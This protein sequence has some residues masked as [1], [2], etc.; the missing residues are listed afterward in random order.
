MQRTGGSVT[1]TPPTPHALIV[2]GGMEIAPDR[3]RELA[4]AASLI[5]AADSGLL[6]LRKGGM[7]PDAVIG[8]LDSL[9]PED[10]ARL[11][12]DQVHHDPGQEDTDLEKAIRFC[13]DRGI[14]SANIVGATGGRL[15]HTLNAISLLLKYSS[16]MTFTLHD[17][18]GSATLATRSPL[19]FD[20]QIG[21]RISLIPAPAAYGL[22]SRGLRYPLDGFDLLFGGRDAVSNAVVSAPVE[23]VW[24]N[25]SFLL[26]RQ[27]SQ[28]PAR[29]TG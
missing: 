25:G 23:I 17:K 2:A 7:E 26:Y 9:T 29:T 3:L 13:A 8:D 14:K 6:L 15:D 24:R 22:S 12:S 19:R 18:D 16:L 4:V 20:G 1:N 28:A 5:V 11:S 10:L 27:S 21:D